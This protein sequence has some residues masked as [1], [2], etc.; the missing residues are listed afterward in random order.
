M[1]HSS[2][3]S[4][5]LFSPSGQLL[6]TASDDGSARI[7]IASSG[8][9]MTEPLV[10]AG[11]VLSAGFSSDGRW[12][13]TGGYEKVEDPSN[14]RPGFA[15]VWD[16]KSGKSRGKPMPHSGEVTC[17]QFS[18]DGREILTGSADGSLRVWDARSGSEVARL[19]DEYDSP[20]SAEFSFDGKLI[21]ASL[22]KRAVVWDWR[23]KKK[24][25]IAHGDT[26]NGAHFSPD[27]KRIVT[28][29][30]DGHCSSVGCTHRNLP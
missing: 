26:V 15:Q 9:P 21:V 11:P 13:V 24:L 2:N 25:E 28:A 7:C 12:L 30:E 16:V 19:A 18:R 29:C 6:V 4:A 3:I 17:V 14:G 10:H 27:G 8:K 20:G 22:F 23:R 1:R 5:A